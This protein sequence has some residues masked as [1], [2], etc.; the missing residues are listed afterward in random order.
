MATIKAALKER[1]TGFPELSALIGTRVFNLT[2]PDGTATP[3]VAFRRRATT[4]R[5]TSLQGPGFR[6]RP[7][8]EFH[9]FAA[10]ADSMDAVATALRHALDGFKGSVL[11]QNI[12]GISLVDEDEDYLNEVGLYH[13]A[14]LFDV[15][16]QED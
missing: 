15:T 9:I 3:Y 16:H 14:Q 5:L 7:R 12:G 10:S 6:V 4:D 8:F 2:A 1:L 11:G 13:A